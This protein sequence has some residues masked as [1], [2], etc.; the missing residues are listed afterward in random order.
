MNPF[1]LVICVCM[2]LSV[3]VQGALLAYKT[4][5]YS[6][7]DGVVCD[8]GLGKC[9]NAAGFSPELTAQFFDVERVELERLAPQATAS[10]TVY[11]SNQVI[12]HFSAQYCESEIVG[13]GEY[14]QAV[15]FSSSHL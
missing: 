13:K 10:A 6:P 3:P 15:L 4:W 7:A 14:Y 12:C 9:Y 11:L 5:V 1:L 8:K 2:V